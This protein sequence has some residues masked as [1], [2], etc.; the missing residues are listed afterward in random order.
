MLEMLRRIE[1]QLDKVSFL[2]SDGPENATEKHIDDC[3]EEFR[4]GNG[5]IN[6]KTIKGGG[7]SYDYRDYKLF[8][9]YDTS[10]D[11]SV[12]TYKCKILNE[13]QET[14]DN[15][16]RAKMEDLAKDIEG[17]IAARRR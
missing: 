13:Y 4:G 12:T 14:V 15:F 7:L 16:S 2:R 10:P 1:A 9:S 11:G 17:F 3:I 6:R 8:F 5:L